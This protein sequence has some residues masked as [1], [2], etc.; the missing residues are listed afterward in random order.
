MKQSQHLL[1]K[2]TSI[3][4]NEKERELVQKACNLSGKTF[5]EFCRI[6][7]IGEAILVIN[8]LHPDSSN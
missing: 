6:A 7:A 4:L 1:R 5:A 3:A 8:Q 2:P